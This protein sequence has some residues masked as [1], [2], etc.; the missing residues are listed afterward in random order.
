MRNQPW[1]SHQTLEGTKHNITSDP[2]V[3]Y[4][5]CCA[6]H[7]IYFGNTMLSIRTLDKR[8]A[9]T[10]RT[11]LTHTSD[12]ERSVP[13]AQISSR[14][15]TTEPFFSHAIGKEALA[16][17]ARCTS[18]D[19]GESMRAQLARTRAKHAALTAAAIQSTLYRLNFG[20]NTVLTQ[21]RQRSRG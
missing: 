11:L 18:R 1:E 21:D 13:Y 5:A 14:S 12:V 3:V 10:I 19:V 20:A 9:G 17:P 4:T 16:R 7:D 2:R 8:K 15:R 6:T